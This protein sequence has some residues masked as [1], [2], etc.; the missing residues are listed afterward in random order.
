MSVNAVRER[1]EAESDYRFR[2]DAE[3]VIDAMH[4]VGLRRGSFG[5]FG[6]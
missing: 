1:A 3:W 4:K 5:I 2:V 6:A